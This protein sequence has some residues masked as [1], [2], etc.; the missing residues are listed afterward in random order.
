[1]QTLKSLIPEINKCSSKSE[2]TI[3]M[4]KHGI[5]KLVSYSFLT[6]SEMRGNT[7]I[8]NNCRGN[9]IGVGDKHLNLYLNVDM[10]L[11]SL[12]NLSEVDF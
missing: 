4:E 10:F 7:D 9:E 12:K 11:N 2:A 3:L 8:E 5:P 6:Y 1:M